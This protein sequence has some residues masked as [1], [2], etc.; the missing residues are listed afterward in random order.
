MRTLAIAA[1][2]RRAETQSNQ[3]PTAMYPLSAPKVA[4]IGLDAAPP[5]LLYDRW[6]EHLPTLSSLRAAGVFGNLRS[7]IPPITVP[8]WA[9][10]ATSKDPGTLG[11]Y[12]F[13]N[14]ID[15][16][17]HALTVA[18][19][20]SI[21]EKRLWDRLG[22]S[23]LRSIVI[24][25]PP[26]YPAQPI[27]GLLVSCF[28]A[29]EKNTSFTYPRW[30]RAKIDDW[31]GGEYV[32]DVKEYRT[33]RKEQLLTEIGQM[34]AAR[35]RLARRM[36]DE[37]W[38]FFMMVEIGTD[39]M[40]HGFL[41]FCHPDHPLYEAGNPYEQAVLAYHIDIDRRVGELVDALP[42]GTLILVVSDH[43]VRPL[44]GGFAINE[45]LRN[46]GLLVL[47]DSAAQG[48]LT[49]DM[50]DWRNTKAWSDGGYYAR[51]FLNIAGREPQGVIPPEERES[52]R[53]SLREKL[54][55]L[56]GPNGRPIGNQVYFP[57]EIYREVRGIA[58][59]LIAF[60][61][62][63]D[64]RAVGAVGLGGM[65]TVG[66]DTGP[67]DANHDMTGLFIAGI[68]GREVPEPANGRHLDAS[69]YDITPTILKSLN[70]PIPAGMIGTPLNPWTSS[71][72]SSV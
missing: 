27:N 6:A 22:D 7:A 50:V 66:N 33:D 70:L 16:S 25:V 3:S 52:F 45:R 28:L 35:F 43:G 11:I 49:P 2:I 56:Q 62:G 34:T 31:A 64:Y 51:I 46:E 21:A 69:I 61:G 4:V 71:G 17:Y 8:A 14:R 57:E 65:F 58:P 30:L 67:D 38:D 19:S 15:N 13:R 72:R 53:Q 12:G 47:K 1:W 48:R 39:R 55:T 44:R 23:G 18:N 5:A 24:G 63:L 54:E 26:T 10:M 32:V 37:T 40:Y 9:C 60:L 68:K 29:P 36:L 20:A 42:D 59:D 41:R